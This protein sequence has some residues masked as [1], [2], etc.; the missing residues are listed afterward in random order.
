MFRVVLTAMDANVNVEPYK[1]VLNDGISFDTRESAEIYMLR[2]MTEEVSELNQPDAY[3][4]P[5]TRVFIADFDGDHDAIV[6]L[7]DGDDYWDVS[8]YDIEETIL[9]DTVPKVGD[10][11]TVDQNLV[12][13]GYILEILGDEAV[14]EID[15]HTGHR[16]DSFRI[17]DL[18]V[19][20]NPPE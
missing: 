4:T 7:W 15:N 13:A 2:A 9:L 18:C 1:E 11:V 5:H 19:V 12:M 6:R 17:S 14:V 8:Y 16:I 20:A 10:F 3:N